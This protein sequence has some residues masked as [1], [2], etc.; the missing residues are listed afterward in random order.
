[1]VILNTRRDAVA[2]LDALGLHDGVFHLSTLLCGKHR[3]A[4]LRLIRC[5]LRKGQPVKLISTQVVEAGV[6]LD[7]PE[8]WRA[9]GP[10]DRIV[11][12]AGRCNREGRLPE[13]G[14]VVVFHPADGRQPAGPYRIGCELARTILERRA[15]DDLHDPDTYREYFQRLFSCADL[16]KKQV[17]EAR[18]ALDFP[19][20]ARRYRMIEETVPVVVSHAGSE[21]ALERWRAKP[22]RAAWRGLQPY[23]VNFFHYEAKQ[24]ADD[25]YMEQVGEGLYR[26]LGRYDSTRGV[27]PGLL[28]PA[29]LIQ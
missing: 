2:L 3:R 23:L 13:L 26:W 11:Q 18:E 6:D 29:D 25:G 7:F 5:R 4:I 19:E 22:S 21:T 1:M 17:Q 10:L 9:V 28:D 24:F 15:G 20:V 27:A 8:V 16:D 14:K 12:A